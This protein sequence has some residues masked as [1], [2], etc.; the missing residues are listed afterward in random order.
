MN[1]DLT[2]KELKRRLEAEGYNNQFYC[3]GSGWGAISDGFALDITPQGFEFFYVERGQKS[4]I[5]CFDNEADACRYTYNFL[6]NEKWSK[7]HLVGFFDSEK[8][9]DECV[10]WLQKKGIEY[11]SDTIPYGG[12]N[13][14]R[15]RV[16]VFG[17]D[18][19]KVKE[20]RGNGF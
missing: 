11:L 4:T 13:D 5:Q 7:S 10:S 15:Y 8:Q 6:A 3:I 2:M 20:L 18:F 14:V 12:P 1:V 16:F 19:R 9:A 17:N